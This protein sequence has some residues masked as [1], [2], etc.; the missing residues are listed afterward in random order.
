M[1]AT[2]RETSADRPVGELKV[3]EYL[4]V[5]GKDLSIFNTAAAPFC[6]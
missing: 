2:F 3:D 1:T 6:F 4:M 5:K